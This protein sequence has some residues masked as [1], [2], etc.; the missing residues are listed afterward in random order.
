[1]RSL[2][3]ALLLSTSPALALDNASVTRT[4]A[5]QLAISWAA[6]GPVDVLVSDNPDATAKTATLVSKADADGS[7]LVEAGIR[8]R[9]Y[10]LLYD[11]KTGE[12]LRV[13]ERL[14]PLEQGSNFRD[15]GGYPAADGKHV[16]WGRLYRSGGQP[17]LTEADVAEIQSL[18]L[19]SMV[20]LRSM[21]E[22]QL[23]PSRVTGVPYTAIGYSMRA[24]MPASQTAMQ[25]GG[26][27][28]RNFPTLLAPQLR[29]IVEQLI[30][31][32]APLAYNCSAGQDRTGFVTAMLLSALGV[33]R[34][35]ILADYHLSTELRHP[36]YEMARITPEAAAADP[37]AAMF[38]R[39]QTPATAKPTPL[40]DA[41]G[42]AFLESAFDEIESRH[43]SVDAYLEREAGITPAA[44]ALLRAKY[45]E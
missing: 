1:M 36:E 22:R 32:D 16:R 37:V 14:V 29:L 20:D 42:R 2:L 7:H 31:D 43:G 35:T 38:A 6:R 27:V 10:I 24:L 30:D 4:N 19:K 26:T 8:D 23:A 40:K 12:T 11:T 21:E 13:A 3:L 15:I 28:Y 33:P 45:L 44:R 34:N 5:N 39:Y 17:L 41:Q 18:G 9:R 25:N